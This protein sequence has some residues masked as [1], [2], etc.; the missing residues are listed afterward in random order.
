MKKFFKKLGIFVLVVLSIMYFIG[1]CTERTEEYKPKGENGIPVY[2]E[3]T[4]EEYQKQM[5]EIVKQPPVTKTSFFKS[6]V[7]QAHAS[8]LT[9]LLRGYWEDTAFFDLENWEI[10]WN[11]IKSTFFK[12][13]SG[14]PSVDEKPVES[15]TV[16]Y[17][18][19]A[20]GKNRI[21]YK[22]GSYEIVECRIYT[23]GA[24]SDKKKTGT[25]K[26]TRTNQFFSTTSF[27][28]DI[29]VYKVSSSF[30]S[31][32]G[33][34]ISYYGLESYTQGLPQS[35]IDTYLKE[36]HFV[37]F[38][39]SSKNALIQSNV[40]SDI[41][42]SAYQICSNSITTTLNHFSI[43]STVSNDY[44]FSQ[45]VN[46]YYANN[47][48]WNFPNVYYNNCAGDTIT[49]SNISN[50][51]EY[52]YTY[53]SVTNGIDFD[54]NVF[55]DFFDLNVKP[56]LEAEFDSI[57]SHFPDIDAEFGDLDVKYNNIIDIMNEINNPPTTTVTGYPVGTGD[58][59]VNV[60][61]DVTFPEEFY[62]KYPALTTEPAFVAENPD[63]DFA[64]DEPL[65]LD[66]LET[67][68]DILS[69]ASDIIT[70]AGLM[71][72]YIMCISLGL[73]ALFLL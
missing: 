63:I 1:S 58:I 32:N 47:G 7:L 29:S 54:P 41:A 22:N 28:F 36:S 26:Y 39:G 10:G 24:R 4:P 27:S 72:V 70:D 34:N 5:D 44:E 31:S 56:K 12:D 11:D 52:G 33:F 68:G 46:N 42:V 50:Y 45:S 15:V 66:I 13:N 57:F 8:E 71:P 2:T 6:P 60:T 65:P 48:Y 64:L 23:T 16:P 59:N 49:Q 35:F 43:S 53:N 40:N 67:S 62:R 38:S 69:M 51:S 14:Y 30:S 9:D 25:V 61:V 37:Y 20:Y 17:Q 3:L 55:A 73:I 21:V 19:E 18:Y